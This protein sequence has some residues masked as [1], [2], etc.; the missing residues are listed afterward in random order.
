M[1]GRLVQ[2]QAAEQASH[3]FGL[4][5]PPDI[6][7]RF[8]VAPTFPLLVIRSGERGD[9]E[10]ALPRWGLIPHWAKDINVGYKMINAKAETVAS[11][12]A[13]RGPLRYRRCVIPSDGF[14]EWHLENKHKQPY[15]IRAR[16]DEPLLLA[17][18]WDYW[19]GQGQG[20]E[21]CTIVTTSANTALGTLHDRMPALLTAEGAR[22]WLDPTL[23]DSKR[24]TPLL[25]PAEPPLTFYKVSTRVNKPI[26]DDPTLIQPLEQARVHR[27]D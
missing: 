3:I 16:R 5:P 1:C 7:S 15:F 2:H 10:W 4:P 22:Q 12:P 23:Q 8:N 17:G 13:Y 21:T 14:Y 6:G 20:L 25:E 26:H 18:L 11:K 27:E 9:H 19:E 24:L